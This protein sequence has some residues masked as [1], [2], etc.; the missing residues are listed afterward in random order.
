MKGLPELEMGPKEGQQQLLQQM[1]E[2][3]NP[4]LWGDEL[5]DQ[6][7]EPMP[8]L[9]PLSLSK[10]PPKSVPQSPSSHSTHSS[11]QISHGS[12]ARSPSHPMYENLRSPPE[13]RDPVH[14]PS[15][16]TLKK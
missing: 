4:T 13:L 6:F 9:Q 15:L 3:L 1:N 8:T 16:G 7:T 14:A 2:N 10:P 12:P 11:S 5:L